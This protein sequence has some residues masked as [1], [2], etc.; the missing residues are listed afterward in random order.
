ME[1]QKSV[2]E[3]IYKSKNKKVSDRDECKFNLVLR[4]F[5]MAMLNL[6]LM[7]KCF[8]EAR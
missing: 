7:K 2:H 5:H 8:D 3:K 1:K 4:L 6:F